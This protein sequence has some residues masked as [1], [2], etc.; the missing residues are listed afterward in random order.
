MPNS[1]ASN[2][3]R[4]IALV[5]LTDE[6]EGRVHVLLGRKLRGFGQGKIVLP[7]GKVEAGESCVDAAIREFR[8]ETGLEVVSDD[9]EL[10]AQINFRFSALESANMDCTTFVTRRAS[11]EALVSDQL[12][13]LWV[14]PQR[15]PIEHMWQDSPLWL[16]KLVAGEKFT[17]TIVLA[18]DNASV[19][20]IHIEPWT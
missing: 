17:A 1:L 9:L 11:G 3:A 19:Q 6:R 5:A 14:D 20:S 7:G 15:L 4:Q 12:Q 18:A 13:P 16:P 10:S 8:E 2:S